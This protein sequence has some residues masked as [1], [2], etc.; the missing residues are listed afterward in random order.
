MA[1]NNCVNS[2]YVTDPGGEA[3]GNIL[4]YGASGWA[5]LATSATAG[6]VLTNNG[7]STNPTWATPSSGITLGKAYPVM[8]GQFSN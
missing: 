4:Y 5:L 7:T 3:Q 2:I 1:T 8:I 6:T